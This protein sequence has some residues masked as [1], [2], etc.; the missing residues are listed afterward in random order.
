MLALEGSFGV[1]SGVARISVMVGHVT[2]ISGGGGSG[3]MLPQINYWI[4]DLTRAIL[5]SFPTVKLHNTITKYDTRI[6]C[7]QSIGLKLRACGKLLAQALDDC[8]R[9]VAYR[10]IDW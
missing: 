4:L 7:I 8:G 5:E 2:K 1:P 6:L 9:G 10:Q 3:G